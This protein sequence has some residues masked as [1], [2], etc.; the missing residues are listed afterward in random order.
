MLIGHIT[1]IFKHSEEILVWCVGYMKNYN[2]QKNKKAIP[3]A[4]GS[5]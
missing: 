3:A 1:T 4:R 5:I 2:P